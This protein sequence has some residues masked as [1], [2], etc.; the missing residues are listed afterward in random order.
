MLLKER[1]RKQHIYG[2]NRSGWKL[3]VIDENI[4]VYKEV[5]VV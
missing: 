4:S 5:P 2:L 3:S 1:N